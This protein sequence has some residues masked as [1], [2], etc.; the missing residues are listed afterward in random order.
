V[1]RP[2]PISRLG[3]QH[4]ARHELS[5]AIYHR[6]GEPWPERALHYVGRLLDRLLEHTFAGGGVGGGGAIAL[7]IVIAAVAALVVWRVG[8]VRRTASIGTV[9][10]PGRS[11]DA[12]DHRAR[13]EQA[14]ARGDWHTAVLERMRAIAREL[15]Q[16]GVLD[17]RPGRTATELA[18][19]AAS[20]LPAAADDLTTAADSFNAVAYGNRA[21]TERTL[22]SLLAADEAIQASAR[23]RA[24]AT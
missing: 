4:A 21:A 9:L 23:S 14:A 12:T 7:V 13:S 3:A 6:G 5:K 22:S 24:L 1:S 16:R 10:E 2:D 20:R 19:E 15:E 18:R 11:V 8:P 17:A